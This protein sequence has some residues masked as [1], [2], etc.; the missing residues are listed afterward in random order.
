M[1]D[2]WEVVGGPKK[3]PVK[4]KP[5]V[6][7]NGEVLPPSTIP[8]APQLQ[9]QKKPKKPSRKVPAAFPLVDD[10]DQPDST[11]AALNGAAPGKNKNKS[12]GGNKGQQKKSTQGSVTKGKEH[13]KRRDLESTLHQVGRRTR[14][15]C[16]SNILHLG[17]F[18]FR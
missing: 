3:R 14:L 9:P 11:T 6:L 18:G 10:D 15:P 17:W 2:K 16:G 1:S 8:G 5:P 4:P 7:G 13:N 12:D